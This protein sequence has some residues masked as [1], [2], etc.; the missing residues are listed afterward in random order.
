MVT[1]KTCFSIAI[2]IF[3]ADQI[4]KV[5]A[6]LYL[7]Q[8]V[9]LIPN[10][11]HLTLVYNEGAA[12]GILQNQRLFFIIISLA[13]LAY[14]C[15]AWK[16]FGKRFTWPLGLLIGGLLGNLVDRLLFGPVTDFIDFRIWPVFNIADSSITISAVWLAILLWK[17]DSKKSASK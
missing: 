10:V 3:I 1:K 16:R 6:R 9:P 4:T 12:F 8:S 14:I 5:L 7:T 2:V 13:V 17:Q 11:L 15:R